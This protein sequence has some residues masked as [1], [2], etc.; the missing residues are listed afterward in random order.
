MKYITLLLKY[1]LG[2]NAVSLLVLMVKPRMF[3]KSLRHCFGAGFACMRRR[4]MI[5]GI[6]LERILGDRKPLI[7]LRVMAYEPGM[8]PS[9]EAMVLLSVAVA[10]QPK[11]VLEIGTFMGHTAR[12]L[13]ENLPS[14]IIHT[15]DLPLAI[16]HGLVENSVVP[17][18]D[19]HLIS[20]RQVGREYQG[21]DCANRIKQHYHD[22]A[23]WDFAEAEDCSFYFIDGSHTY[24]HVKN[25]SEKCM[26]LCPDNA[27]FIWHDCDDLHPGVQRFIVEWRNLGRDVRLIKGTCLAYWKYVR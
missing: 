18:D 5:P 14:S 12:L 27:V 21:H 10:E 24:E 19:F 4:E 13:A 8:L 17:K 25:D 9:H 3:A 7:K 6:S 22:T 23:L 26:N 15:V 2:F 1:L 11:E 16:E 20:S